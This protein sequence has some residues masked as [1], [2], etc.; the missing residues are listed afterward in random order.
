MLAVVLRYFVA[1]AFSSYCGCIINY[2]QNLVS[3]NN[4]VIYFAH[5][6]AVGQDSAGEGHLCSTRCP[7]GQLQGW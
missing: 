3:Q 6:P 5:E 4:N 1:D 2:P 7:L